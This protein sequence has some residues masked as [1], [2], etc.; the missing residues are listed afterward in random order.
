V[1]GEAMGIWCVTKAKI[2]GVAAYNEM[3]GRLAL[4]RRSG[5]DAAAPNSTTSFPGTIAFE[6]DAVA[7]AEEIVIFA[8]GKP[9]VLLLASRPARPVMLAAKNRQWLSHLSRPT[10]S[11]SG[12]R[13]HIA[14][15]ANPRSDDAQ[16]LYGDFAVDAL[17]SR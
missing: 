5:L 2:G 1:V 6:F 15:I 4:S 17:A 13:L 12:G 10:A 14:A 11:S 7:I 16:V 9:A 8:T 3:P